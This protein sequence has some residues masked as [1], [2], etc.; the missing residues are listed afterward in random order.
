MQVKASHTDN[1]ESNQAMVMVSIGKAPA[2]CGS[3]QF[4]RNQISFSVEA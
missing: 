2:A 1:N 4:N 3:R